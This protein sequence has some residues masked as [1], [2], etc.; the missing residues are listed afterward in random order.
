MAFR[1]ALARGIYL[2]NGTILLIDT[3]IDS[4]DR[5]RSSLRVNIGRKALPTNLA[6]AS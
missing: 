3:S 1:W 5:E 4:N 2:R 6:A